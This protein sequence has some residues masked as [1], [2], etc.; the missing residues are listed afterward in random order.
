MATFRV[1]LTEEERRVL[2]KIV[3]SGKGAARTWLHGRIVL[4]AEARPAGMQDTDEAM[5]EA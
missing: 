1:P 5:A 4:Q 3:S 2:R